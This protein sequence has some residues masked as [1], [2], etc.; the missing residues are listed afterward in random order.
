MPQLVSLVIH[1]PGRIDAIVRAW[2]G[3]GVSGLTLL[4]SS[5]LA[6]HL[7]DQ[8]MRDDLPLFPSMRHLLQSPER[9]N[10]LLFSVVADDFDVERLIQATEGAIGRLDDPGTGILFVLPVTRVAGLQPRRNESGAGGG[11]PPRR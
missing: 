9:Q 5:G 4:D 2:V 8:A 1:D 6:H 11:R 7:R 3:V 10:R